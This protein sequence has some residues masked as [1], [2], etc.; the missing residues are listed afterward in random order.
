[1]SSL[2]LVAWVLV[3]LL[4]A[5]ATYAAARHFLSERVSEEASSLSA[6]V[7]FRLSSLH[8]LIL[9]LIFAQE[10][11]N[12]SRLNQSIVNES[13]AIADLFYDLDRYGDPAAQALRGEM[14]LYTELVVSEEWAALAENALSEEAWAAWGRVYE[15]VLDLQPESLRQE[16]LRTM[17]LQDIDRISDYRD[18]RAAVAV[19]EI[20]G[21]FWVAGIG[22]FVAVIFLYFTFAPRLVNLV[23]LAVYSAY[24]GLI[25][26]FIHAMNN[27]FR[28]DDLA[29]TRPFV[30]LIENDFA[31]FEPAPAR[32]EE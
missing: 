9:A 30:A 6:S 2:V 14:V 29:E 8:G 25:L 23:M 20:S 4:V 26:V 27:P 7:V 19:S 18:V 28:F 15:G 22:G 13:I 17:M 3:S 12:L 5:G 24:V 16:T 32:A 21:L 1:M 31:G 11:L 10:Q